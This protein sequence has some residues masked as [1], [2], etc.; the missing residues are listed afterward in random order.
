MDM[1]NYKNWG[2][3]DWFSTET[4]L[5]VRGSNSA[6]RGPSLFLCSACGRMLCLPE[7]AP[8]ST[9]AMAT[10]GSLEQRAQRC[11]LESI[12]LWIMFPCWNANKQQISY[13]AFIFWCLFSVISIELMVIEDGCNKTMFSCCQPSCRGGLGIRWYL[14]YFFPVSKLCWTTGDMAVDKYIIP[15]VLQGFF[16]RYT[17]GFLVCRCGFCVCVCICDSLDF[18][19]YFFNKSIRLCTLPFY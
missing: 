14:C 3:K 10:S 16:C 13:S 17:G 12:I 6:S 5:L 11:V 9:Q 18:L 19:I 4:T 15:S 7:A 2:M 8:T 1:R